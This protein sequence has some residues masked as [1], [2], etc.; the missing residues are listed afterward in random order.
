MMQDINLVKDKN[1]KDQDNLVIEDERH[2][3]S[4]SLFQ[5]K[6]DHFDV[7]DYIDEN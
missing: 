4:L 7:N 2:Y 6:Y 3:P 5:K 1:S